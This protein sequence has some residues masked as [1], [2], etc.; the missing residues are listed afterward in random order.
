V[1]VVTPA[2]AAGAVEVR[3]VA[4]VGESNPLAY[5]YADP[6]AAPTPTATATK[7]ARCV[8]PNLYGRTLSAA[9]QRLTEAGCTLG[10]VVRRT[11]Q[12]GAPNARVV[13]QSARPGTTH[14]DGAKVT[15]TT[16]KRR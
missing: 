11:A 10:R 4:P 12:R 13:R 6:P 16:R 2:R 5:T 15:V 7:T 8:V 3:V 14:A 1:E 9:R